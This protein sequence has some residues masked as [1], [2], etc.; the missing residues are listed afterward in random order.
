MSKSAGNVVD[1]LKIIDE[2]GTDAVR[3]WTYNSQLGTDTNFSKDIIKVGQKLVSKIFNS[4]KF[5]EM[6]LENMKDEITTAKDDV[7]SGLIYEK[8]DLWIL[9]KLRK[10]IEKTGETFEAYEYGK[11]REI[12]EDFFWNDFCDNY[13]EIAKVRCYGANGTKYKDSVLSNEK[14][15]KINKG[16]QSALRT[17]YYTFNAILKLFSPFIPHITE[18]VY[19]NV[20]EDEFRKTMFLGARGNWPKYGN[21]P[22][23]ETAVGE[24]ALRIVFEVRKYKSEQNVSI[25]EMIENIRIFSRLFY[26]L[27]EIEEDLK[28]VCNV[29]NIEFADGEFAVVI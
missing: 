12:I 23:L 18:E 25:K 29:G 19:S 14:L 27:K 8:I 6:C 20:Y 11:A 21:F 1:P 15:E 26:Q 9:T 7:E 22:N 24:E 4:G 3:Y 10:V 28:N 2:F 16:Q 17:L 13:L 5:V